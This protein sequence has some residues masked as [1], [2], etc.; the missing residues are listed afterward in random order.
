LPTF[1]EILLAHHLAHHPHEADGVEKTP[2]LKVMRPYDG[3]EHGVEAG[4][5]AA[6]VRR[7]NGVVQS[8]RPAWMSCD[9]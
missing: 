8:C 3:P 6:C 5:G 9:D 7:I 4:V 2:H 1:R